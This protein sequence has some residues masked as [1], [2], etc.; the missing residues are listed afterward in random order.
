MSKYSKIEKLLHKLY[1]S[2]HFISKSSLEIEELLFGS[3]IKRVEIDQYI[4]VTG[5]AR[6]GTTFLTNKIYETSDY[7]SLQYSNM[8]FLFLPNLW[9]NNKEITSKERAH[10]DGIIIN[11]QSP[12][13]FDEYFWKVFLLNS[14]V[15]KGLHPH[16]ISQSILQK[17]LTYISL[18]CLSKN[19]KRYLSK[20]NNNILRLDSL[21]K[22]KN[23]KIIILYR[24]PLE[25]ASSLMK[26]HNKF[27]KM[28]REDVF[29]KQYFDFLGHYE[30]GLNHK[31]F[32]L[33]EYFLKEKEKYS[34]S[35]INYWLLNWINYYSYLLKN[36]KEDYILVSFEDLVNNPKQIFLSISKK[37][38]CQEI[39]TQGKTHAPSKYSYDQYDKILLRKAEN[40]YEKL[41]IL[42]LGQ[43]TST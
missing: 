34:L 2:N 6:S 16:P 25:H 29:V 43:F 28:Q 7:A 32:L 8:P 5:L 36:F 10:Q 39:C 9:K 4:F 13:E 1:L 33:T 35:D 27:M 31:P 40:I 21:S 42:K 23:S 17:Y 3:Q 26:M 30:F 22:V 12:E 19:K 41:E 15:K 20:N 38:G 37:L 14:Y 11:S 18:I 24:N